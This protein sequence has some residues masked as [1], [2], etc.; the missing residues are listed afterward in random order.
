MKQH[1]R[2]AMAITVMVGLATGA[3]QAAVVFT[4]NFE[5]PTV[6]GYDQQPPL[7]SGWVAAAQGYNAS[8]HG[9]NNKSSGNFTAPAGNNQAYCFRYTNSGLTTGAGVIGVL[10]AN[11]T[12][13]ISFNVATDLG[14]PPGTAYTVQL[15]A[16]GTG[17]ARDD[18]R[19]TPSGSTLL[20]S[21]TGTATSNNMSQSDS[22]SFTASD[23]SADLG[24]DIG[25]RLIGATSAALIDNVQV[26]AV[27]NKRYWDISD[28][29]PGAG[30]ATP[31]G[32]W[33]AANTLWNPVSA[34]TGTAAAWTAGRV[35]TFA[36]GTDA[37]GSYIVTV[38]GLQDISGLTFEEGTVTLAAGASPQLRLTANSEVYVP[39]L[40]TATVAAPFTQDATPRVL[41]KVGP[42]MLALS[43]DN[44]AATG[45]MAINGGAIR[46]ESAAAI[47]GTT[48]NVTVNA[49]GTVVFGS[50]FGAGNIPA[51]LL[52]RIVAASAG[53][54]AAD[55]YDGTAFN[56]NTPSLTAAS[57][58]AVGSVTY[59][60]A[61]TPNGT[62]YR[63]GGGGGTLTMANA[64]ALTGARTLTVGG[65]GTVVLSADNNYTSGTTLN[66]G[67]LVI[68]SA[69]A[70]G[71]GTLTIAGA[72]T[73]R[74]SGTVVIANTVAANSDFS[75]A[76]TGS[77]TLSGTTTLNANRI[78]TLNTTAG[79]TTFAGIGGANR[80]LTFSG[81]GNTAVSGPITTGTGTLTKN[82]T[83]TLLLSGASTY[84]GVT[85]ISAS[86][87]TLQFAKQVSLY[88]NNPANWLKT[89]II[90]NTGSTLALNVGGPGEFTTGDITTLLANL[91]VGINN[92]GLRSGSKIAFD[93]ANASPSTFAVADN[94]A[95]SGGTGGGA[96]GLRKLGANTLELTG[97]NTYTGPTTVE[98]GALLVN[99]PGSL[100]SGSAVAV[101]GGTLGGSG[102]IGGSVTV[103]SAGSLAPGAAAGTLAIGGNLDISAMAAGTGKLNFELDAQAGP[104]DRV[105][106]SGTL[107]IGAGA[108]GFSDFVFTDLGGVEV[109]TYTLITSSG[110]HGGDSLDGADL[111]GPFA[112]MTGTLQINGNNLELV[113][114]GGDSF[115]P[116]VASLSPIN[117]ATGV[118]AVA[119]LNATFN[120][121]IQLIAG[122]VV[123][124]MNLTDAS[125][126]PIT[127]PDAQVSAAGAVLTINPSASLELGDT[128]AVL[129]DGNAV[130]D[131]AGNNFAGIAAD[132]A[133]RFTVFQVP[134][135]NNAGGATGLGI[136]TATLNGQVVSDGD[137]ALTHVRIYFG[138]ND[139]GATHNWDATH[140]FDAG[141]VAEGVP[142]SCNLAGLLYGVTYTY[143]TYAA[144]GVGEVWSAPATFTTLAPAG[145]GA[146]GITY[147]PITGDAD[148]GISDTTTYT[149]AVDFGSDSPRALINGVQ[150]QAG[151]TTFG[152]IA[153][154]AA[155]IGTGTTTIPTAHSG[156]SDAAPYL[157]GAAYCHMEDLV[158]DMN[159]N[160]A[161][162]IIT[163]TG[164]TPG[165][166][167]RF[168]LYNRQWGTT[169]GSIRG[170]N[171]GFDTDG[172]GSD[173]SGAEHTAAFEADDASQ[174]DP[175]FGTFSQVYALT[176][177]YAL[178][179]GVSTLTVYV[180]MKA[181]DSGTYHL[182]GLTNEELPPAGAGFSITNTAATNITA[183]T[184]D[185]VGTLNATQS[186][187]T[188]YAYYG[189]NDNADAAAW[190]ADGDAASVLVGTFT[191]VVGHSVTGSVS[192]LIADTPYYY[193][194]VA[195]NAVT[196]IWATPNTGFTSDRPPALLA[197]S[198]AN[199]AAGVAPNANL[200]AAFDE[201]IVLVNGGVITLTNLTAETATTIM[202]PDAQVTVT[203]DTN[204]TINPAANLDAGD[205]Y[206]VLIDA[207]AVADTVANAY[208]GIAGTGTWRFTVAA[209]DAI[210]PVITG[211]SPA[212]NTP[213]S[214]VAGNLVATFDESIVLIPG[215][216]V[217]LTNLTD[218]TAT[219][220]TLPDAR[221]SAAG[222][223]LTINPASNLEFGDT[224]AVLVDGNAVEDVW[225]NHFAGIAADTAWRLTTE[226]E[227]AIVALNPAN[228]ATGVEPGDNLVAT[229]NKNIALVA[230]GTITIRNLTQATDTTITLP[231]TRVSAAGAL[232]TINPAADLL[233]G[234]H[235]AVR[236]DA[237]AVEDLN[238]NAFAGIAD[239]A[240]WNVTIREAVTTT[241]TGPNTSNADTWNN[242]A[243]WN[244]GVPTGQMNAVIPVGKLTCCWKADTTPTPTYT[245]N[246]TINGTLQ[247]GW[248]TTAG[249]QTSYNSLGAVGSTTIFMGSG[250]VIGTRMGGTPSFPAIQLNGNATISFG[251]STQTPATSTFGQGITGAYRLTLQSN[252]GNPETLSTA[253]GFSELILNALS[254]RGGS[255]WTLRANAAGSLGTGNV[256]VNHTSNLSPQLHIGAA[257][258]MADTAS[259]YLNGLGPLGDGANRLRLDANDTIAK[260]FLNGVQQ[261]Y[262][263]YGRVGLAG[264]DYNVSWMSASGNGVLTVPPPPSGYWDLNGAT[265]GAGS[266]SPAGTWD[267]VSTYWN[268]LDDGSGSVSSWPAGQPA[269]FAAGSDAIGTYTVT[270]DG[271]HDTSGLV[272]E[273]GTVTLAGGTLRLTAESAAHVA[274]G[275]TAT[276]S[277]TLANDAT[278][279]QLS[280]GGDGTLVLG[281]AN[282]YAGSTKLEGGTLSVASLA[283]AGA[284][285]NIGSYPMAGAG[286]LLF[287]GGT[288]RYTGGTVSIDRG[289][290]LSGSA[291]L[292]VN[293]AGTALTLGD[294]VAATLSGTL[295]VTGGAG[296]S[297]ALGDFRLRNVSAT[298]NPTAVS[299]TLATVRGD[300]DYGQ[301]DSTLT[302][303]GT[304]TGN[305]IVGNLTAIN[306]HPNGWDK[307]LWIAKS[308]A[309]SWA[310]TGAI[311]CNANTGAKVTVDGGTLTL[312]NPNSTYSG[313]LTVRNGTLSVPLV[314]N[315]SA[316]GPLGNS[317]AAVSL[318]DTGGQ[319]GMLRYTG[320]TA[321]STKAFT[322][323]TGGTGTFQVDSGAAALTLSGAIGG[324][325]G[326]TKTG[327]GTLILAGA[328]SHSGATAVDNGTLRV[329]SSL[330]SAVVTIN[331]G[332]TL[333]GTGTLG[334]SLSVLSGG[335]LAPG[336]S[337]GTLTAANVVIAV[338]GKLAIEID[339]SQTPT[340]DVLAVGGALNI[341]GATLNL[342]FSG[343]RPTPPYVIATYGALTGTFGVVNGLPAGSAINYGYNSGT[344]IAIEPAATIFIVR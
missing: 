190:L 151:G 133:W 32:L 212:S 117:N 342:A 311:N 201:N 200:V 19:S 121:N 122:G 196:N 266:A 168:R 189:P 109:G 253:N 260:L 144:N 202:L 22:F 167:Y 213:D 278:A 248:T 287:A 246:L 322:M 192:S 163:L 110:I 282:T 254:G 14:S 31:A 225:G 170:Q 176:C 333:G 67:T 317:A 2:A 12:Y 1:T 28:T 162:G 41:T 304:T 205:T 283:N 229:F 221:I 84:S 57:L 105:A 327:T 191:N 118:N 198:P 78:I 237:T 63:L 204:L 164:L 294:V 301:P 272:F 214:P 16:F 45:G 223:Q 267:A 159:Y 240:T 11:V 227:P 307:G 335:T 181:G 75:I 242:A 252:A 73:V 88:N 270:V 46:F 147:H 42:G 53:A 206:A 156:S 224:Y 90:V 161:T 299:L 113:I 217:T 49:A 20:A 303:S 243:N 94:I 106:V 120:E 148:C 236:I 262:G 341:T 172:V 140:V 334:G 91:A 316:N 86:G 261:P 195:S 59:T 302:L 274:A 315:A 99:S 306:D 185:L 291:T 10:A 178:S 104:N 143:R 35:A 239:D 95:N 68:G 251:D 308:G 72:G 111:S 245:G 23:A 3:V 146:A 265:A 184:A 276:V 226:I 40:F 43:G 211:L 83:G 186:V 56:F 87:G 285:C 70:L 337:T 323:A 208:A 279:W 295:T 259:L 182:Y 114:S 26:D 34:G 296:S 314:N 247:I 305:T 318:G 123:T 234:R 207:H 312:T 179:P 263:T 219:A 177:D 79:T 300:T 132:T 220:I 119:D 320:G 77:L 340:R 103:A 8:R 255:Q 160:D 330:P 27:D 69:T 61:L 142:F 325:G 127:L 183:T 5:S 155:T 74:A 55:N 138:D 100:A 173:I 329:S 85:T 289:F 331:N 180:N 24:K 273:E 150:F 249:Y 50:S 89:L 135:V 309:G 310:I 15:I 288:L 48:R 297:L 293:G 54:V 171:I 231:D 52:G 66:G 281:G 98:A 17:A 216:V 203:G 101:N 82:G 169:A 115:P 30:G 269:I 250:A 232:L 193:T 108:L 228:N 51:A 197:L 44:S 13:T 152:S 153:G 4:A 284:N 129:I 9:L 126:T 187:F 137:S 64:N 209:A 18:C 47:N 199:N 136:G 154:T 258:A 277:S 97:V 21:R 230:G 125:A 338:G 39:S 157:N 96:I 33:N 238:G 76:G 7:P 116:T 241:Y 141:A 275:L 165:T 344:A 92:N 29:T 319:T 174:P 60:G 175:S 62:A 81:N 58:G 343:A 298:L 244:N 256:T 280:K 36:A 25:I 188:V 233:V 65:S 112:G 313:A 38:D 326:L 339:G 139:G 107:A 218:H 336:A 210:P 158:E 80:T 37:T 124:L 166:S 235:Y 264:V 71:S 332:G 102:A 328:N 134:T 194:L 321:S 215:G 286:G 130:E 271:T 131:P 290:T 292:D 268:S 145:T 128:Y 6:T 93:T 222:T 257:N 149:H 324:S